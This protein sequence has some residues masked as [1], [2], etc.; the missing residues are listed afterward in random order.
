MG[1]ERTTNAGK[2]YN[3]SFQSQID[4]WS[5]LLRHASREHPMSVRE[6]YETLQAEGSGPSLN[7]LARYLPQ[8]T[9]ALDA[10]L[11][12]Q[13]LHQAGETAIKH[14]YLHD[15]ALHVVLENGDGQAL[16]DGE[17]TAVFTPAIT[18]TP[19]YSTIDNLL[20]SYPQEGKPHSRS[21]LQLKCV[22]AR[23]VA[24]KTKYIPYHTWIN[25]YEEGKAPKNQPR[26]YYLESALTPAEWRI[27][28]D[29]IKVYPYI[30]QG[31]T[32]K[33]LSAIHCM[34]PGNRDYLDS[35]RYAFKRGG[36]GHFFDHIAK[37]D[38]AIRKKKKVTLQYGE[39]IL[40]QTEQGW[41]PVLR[42]R[43]HAG[44]LTVDPYALMWSNGYYYLVGKDR[45]MMNLRV[46]RI[47]SV[48]EGNQTFERDP[49]FDPFAY[50]DKSPVMYP[51][52]P[53]FVRMRC[54][55]E[56][57]NTILDFF[58]PQAHFSAPQDGWTEVHMSIAPSGV[59]LFAL[60]YA[61]QVEVLEPLALRGEIRASLLEALARYQETET[62]GTER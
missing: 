20:K 47:L 30:S 42:R 56:L 29:L 43:E 17:M 36:A 35:S 61:N 18:S 21:P 16:W 3:N 23:T 37:L 49:G 27:L 38:A 40:R 4:I 34:S 14:T 31:Q 12:G 50:R 62:A 44:L 54:R 48:A 11:P 39:Y 25:S 15:G 55:L 13:T 57:L 53:Q 32:N 60:Q 28:S 46:D 45:G 58:G 2:H 33:F 5:V 22:A 52:I 9:E 41:Q 6:I 1:N 51:G 26:Y 19:K 8:E 7:T 24:G 59:K 10:L